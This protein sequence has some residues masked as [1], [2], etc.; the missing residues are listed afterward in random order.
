[1]VTLDALW[2]LAFLNSIQWSLRNLLKDIVITV[3]SSSV[4]SLSCDMF[5]NSTFFIFF[6]QKNSKEVIDVGVGV[7]FLFWVTVLE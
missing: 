2:S 5:N 3:T 6:R 1:M 7:L 4:V